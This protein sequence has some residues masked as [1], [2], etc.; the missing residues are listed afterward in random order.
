MIERGEFPRRVIRLIVAGGRGGDEADALGDRRNCREQVT[1][2][3]KTM[4]CGQRLSAASFPSRT[5]TASAR[6]IR[7][8]LPRSAVCARLA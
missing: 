6:N 4:Y 5:A 2:S 1:G 3:K 8:N 7:S